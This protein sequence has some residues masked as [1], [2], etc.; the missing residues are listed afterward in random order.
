MGDTAERF[1]VA[2]VGSGPAGLSAAARA[3]ARGMSHVLVEKAGHLSDTIHKYQKGKHVMATPSNLVLRSDLDFEAGKREAVLGTWDEQTAGHQVNVRLNT[4]IVSITGAKGDFTLAVKNGEPIRAEAVVLAIG[5]QGNPNLVRCPVGEGAV[6][7]YQLDDPAEYVDEHIVVI[8]AGDAGIENA[9]GLAADPQQRNV[10]TIVNRSAEFN[11]AKDANVKALQAMQAEGRITVLME[12][13]ARAI[14]KGEIVFDTRDGELRMRCDRVIA[15]MGSAPPRAFVEGICAEFEE[16][17]GRKVVRPGTGVQFTSADRVAYPKLSPM[18]ESTVPGVYVIGALAGYPLIKHCMNQGYDVIEFIAGNTDL[19]PADE[20]ILA[21]KFA[22]LPG[23]RSVDEWLALFARNIEIF[24]EVSPLQLRELML[25]SE[26]HAFAA[27]ETLFVRNE[28]GSSLFAIAEGSVL[29]EVD[30]EDSSK[31]VP[32]GQGSIVGE[33]GLISGRPRG[34]TVRAAEPTVCVELSRRAALKLL[35]TAPAAA[36]AVN[37]IAIERQLLQIFGSGLKPEDVAGLVEAAEVLDVAAGKVVIAE[38]ADDKDV[39]VVR[40]GSMIVEKAI[41]G[42]PVFL[43]YLPAGSYLGEMAAIDGSKRTATV[44]AAIRSEVVRFPGE[45]FVALLEAKPKL[46]EKALADMAGR[47]AVTQF[48]EG[49]KDSFGSAV[50]YYSETAQFLVDNGIGE[51]T[52]VLLIDEKLCVGCDNCE[53]ACADSHDGLS[54]LDRE[55][56]RT[57]AHLHV[58]TSCRHCEHPHCMADCPPDA[59]RRGADG[60]VFIAETCIG[61]GNCQR[62][63]PYGVIRMDAKPPRKPSLLSWI[64]F[65]AGPG[66]GEASYAWRKANAQGEEAKL[67]IKCD[68]C[69]G[70]EGGPACVRACPTGAAIRVS[71]E[72]FLRFT[73]LVEDVG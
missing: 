10:V 40:R 67:A 57:Y 30:P 28:P 32:I 15:R 64:L 49:R 61:C 22:P 7:Q 27:G 37:R 23:G 43:S 3:A 9:L 63:C 58:P 33:V 19:K 16:K 70:I 51:A 13:T 8:G 36:R 21:A 6:V 5:T 69:S 45:A 73:K 53:K 12:T 38:G 72:K 71:P 17:N 1:K 48:I 29:V 55:A 39:Y 11:T 54:R 44:K 35:A 14:D 20:P 68:M 41:G 2:I 4:E 24:R 65:G 47:R 46:R 50:D 66:P 25:E 59:I 18:F 60:E 26:A 56:G 34:S 52:D 31:T 62:N 42:K